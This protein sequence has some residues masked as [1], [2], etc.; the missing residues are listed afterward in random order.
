MKHIALLQL[1]YCVIHYKTY[2]YLIDNSSPCGSGE[3]E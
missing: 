2:I 1:D 3:V